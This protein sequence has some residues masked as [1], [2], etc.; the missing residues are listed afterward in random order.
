MAKKRL[1]VYTRPKG[2]K[3][4]GKMKAEKYP[5]KYKAYKRGA[6]RKGVK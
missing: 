1:E 3:L 2:K 5:P 4:E 6:R